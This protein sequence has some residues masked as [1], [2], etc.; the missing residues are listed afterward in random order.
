MDDANIELT[1][2][3]IV[4]GAVGTAGQRCTTTRRVFVHEAVE[5]QLVDKLMAAYKSIPI[6]DPALEGTLMG[7]LIDL[8]PCQR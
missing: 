3:G 4:F 7:P 5:N 8:W 1:V 6:G 2:R